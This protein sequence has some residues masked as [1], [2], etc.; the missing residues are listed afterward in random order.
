MIFY[1]H[2]PQ[3]K[4]GASC[5]ADKLAAWNWPDLLTAPVDISTAPKGAYAALKRRSEA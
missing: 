5:S 1:V 4:Q 3:P 2:L